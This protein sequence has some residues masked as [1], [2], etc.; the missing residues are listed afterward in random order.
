MR[1]LRPGAISAGA[2]R[3]TAKSMLRGKSCSLELKYTRKDAI[4]KNFYIL[5]E[6]ERKI[7]NKGGPETFDTL[8]LF[9]Q[10]ISVPSQ[11]R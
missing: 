6:N 2:L 7:T 8:Y 10:T 5:Y 11:S 9:N 1:W 4:F 3:K